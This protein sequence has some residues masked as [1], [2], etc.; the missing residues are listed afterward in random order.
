MTMN[1]S[2]TLKASAMNG[3]RPRAISLI[4][5]STVN[6]KVNTMFRYEK[7]YRIFSGYSGYLSIERAIV[8]RMITIIINPL[9]CLLRMIVRHS[10][11]IEFL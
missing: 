5:A 2:N 4:I 11:T 10:L 9:K 7:N 1:K 3:L 8:F 6:T